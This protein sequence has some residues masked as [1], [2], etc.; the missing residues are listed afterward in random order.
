MK[1]TNVVPAIKDQK[2]LEGIK[3]LANF[4]NEQR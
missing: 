3:S 1:N 4:F 2:A